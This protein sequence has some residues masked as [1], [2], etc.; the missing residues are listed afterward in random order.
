LA[1]PKSHLSVLIGDDQTTETHTRT[2]S[3]LPA[4]DRRVWRDHLGNW[5]WPRPWHLICAQTAIWVGWTAKETMAQPVGVI[6]RIYAAHQRDD[7][8]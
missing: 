7:D 1:G 8:D 2:G 3:P 4:A 5:Q 6:A